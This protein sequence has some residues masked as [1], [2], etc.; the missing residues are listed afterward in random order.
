MIHLDSNFRLSETVAIFHF[1]GRQ[2][3]IP[4]PT[5]ARDI[6]KIDEFLEWNHNSLLATT[7]LTFYDA[8]VKPFRP[9]VTIMPHAMMVNVNQPL[10]YVELSQSLSDLENLWLS[11]N[12]F[13]VGN[14]P[15]FADLT[16]T[17]LIMQIVGLQIYKLD[18]VK[19]PKV[20]RWLENVRQI[21][22][23]EFDDAH[24]YVY[25]MGERFKGKPP[26][27]AV[28]AFRFYQSFRKFMK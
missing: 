7:G 23:P 26:F 14:E 18:E 5:D 11:E 17:C 24:K 6:A 20:V 2:N 28:M 22:N 27:M 8:F 10:N 21:H 15:T 13:L 19:F 4:Y 9:D 1:L 12:K 16:A 25:K 3:I